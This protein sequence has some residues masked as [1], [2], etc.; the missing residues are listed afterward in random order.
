MGDDGFMDGTFMYLRCKPASLILPWHALALA[1]QVVEI[2]I[3]AHRLVLAVGAIVVVAQGCEFRS[4][5][6]RAIRLVPLV[7]QIVAFV[8]NLHGKRGIQRAAKH[9]SL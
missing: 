8:V 9:F 2:A 4:G 6:N 7:P 5:R 3:L 1:T